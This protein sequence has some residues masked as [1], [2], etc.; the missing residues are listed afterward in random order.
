MD[1]IV[2]KT[3]TSDGWPCYELSDA[4]LGPGASLGNGHTWVNVGTD[5]RIHTFFSVDVGEEVMGPLIVRYAG[6]Q[7]RMAEGAVSCRANVPLVQV[8]EGTVRI[9]PAFQEHRFQLPGQLAVRERVFVPR[10]EGGLA[11]D[12]CLAY[13]FVEVLNESPAPRELSVFAF[14]R[15][16][17]SRRTPIVSGTYDEARGAIFASEP[18]NPQ[19]VRI[20]SCTES[21]SAWEVTGDFARCYDTV[22]IAPLAGTADASGDVL[23]CLEMRLEID[24]GERAGFAFF[25]AFAPDGPEEAGRLLEKA[26][27][28][29][30]IWDEA[31][32]YQREELDACRVYTPDEDINDGAFWSKVNM[33]RVLGHFPLGES[34]TN[35]PGVSSNVVARDAVWFVYGCDHFRPETSRRLLDAFVR[36]QYPD[37]KIP[38]YYNARTGEVADYG[39]N[40]NDGTPL[41][42]LG[43]NHHVRSTGDFDY[44]RTVYD[45]VSRAARYIMSQRD[46]RGLVFCDADGVEVW[47]IASWR[48]VIPNYRINGAVTEINAEC[49]A[50]LRAMGHMADNIG[51]ADD[52]REFA[53]AADELTEALNEHL[54]DR[55]LN[56]YVLNIDREG[57]RQTDVTADEL[58]PVLFR[59]A[60]EDVAFHIIRRLDNADFWT[61]A[62]LRTAS[63][64][65]PRYDPA[66]Y[67]GLLGGVWP[68]ATWWYAFAA[69]HYH[70]EFMVRALSASYAH[71]NRHPRVFNTVPGQFSEWFDGES[72]INRGM[73]L[74][75]WEPPR[76]LWAA[77]EG[78]C[79]VMVSPDQPGIRPLIPA[80]WKWVALADVAY[81]GNH[82]TAFAAREGEQLHVWANT[83]FRSAGPKDVL[84]EDVT[85]AL[86]VGHRG[87]YA[88]G[89]RGE[90]RLVV[91]LGSALEHATTTPLDISALLDAER[92]YTLRQYSSERSDWAEDVTAPGRDLADLGVRLEAGGYH[93]LEFT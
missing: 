52:A 26:A 93:V 89:L 72:L 75:P 28:V 21:P 64:Q 37:G 32:L 49:A 18:D 86:D 54:L 78:V 57:R 51:R 81:H 69:A 1:G 58:F 31:L 35:E 4:E 14:T 23:A 12:E 56:L 47:G 30:A 77:V 6:P 10:G 33:L 9:H 19:W 43:V 24:A 29:D 91:A 44:L 45:S 13:Y 61:P 53:R 59:V 38:E 87:V 20:V 66:R 46:E 60:P 74:S 68:G 83:D 62:G 16:A 88:V 90:G 22:S 73:R 82:I 25:L 84:A 17:G 11:G 36:H 5:G 34:F 67:V 48:N 50:A 39:L 85:R 2:G 80:D 41:F 8:G 79:G 15:L 92:T 27:A 76:F 55:D 40:I 42:V 7:T 65:D 63:R 3:M 70:P 71:Y